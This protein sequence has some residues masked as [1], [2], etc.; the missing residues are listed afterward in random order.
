MP[1]DIDTEKEFDIEDLKHDIEQSRA[2]DR[3]DDA[4][5]EIKELFHQIEWNAVANESP[6]ARRICDCTKSTPV[7]S[8]VTVCST[9]SRAL[10]SMNTNG[11]QSLRPD[12]ST[13]NSKVPRLL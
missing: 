8:S 6:A 5:V 11:W 9:C 10:A 4:P 3:W 2:T 7:T 12:T 13:R 1:L